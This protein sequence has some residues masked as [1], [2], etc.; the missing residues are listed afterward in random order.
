MLPPNTS[1]A[2]HTVKRLFLRNSWNTPHSRYFFDVREEL[3]L[4]LNSKDA[5]L[6]MHDCSLWVQF[7]LPAWPSPTFPAR[8]LRNIHIFQGVGRIIRNQQGLEPIIHNKSGAENGCGRVRRTSTPRSHQT[9]VKHHRVQRQRKTMTRTVMCAARC[10]ASG[11]QAAANGIGKR[12]VTQTDG[13]ELPIVNAKTYYIV[14]QGI[15]R[16]DACKSRYMT[17]SFMQPRR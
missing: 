2:T 10:A 8:T 14:F 6:V 12:F 5:K 16:W 7:L 4:K 11:V 17:L 9:L 13:S 3:V 15:S 1:S